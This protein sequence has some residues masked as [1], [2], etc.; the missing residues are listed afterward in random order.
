MS[1][2]YHGRSIGYWVQRYVEADQVSVE[3]ATEILMEIGWRARA[4]AVPVALEMLYDADRH[5]EYRFEAATL[6][7]IVGAVGELADALR[8]DDP[9]VREAALT[10][11]P[12][13]CIA[14]ARETA[15]VLGDKLREGTLDL[16]RREETLRGILH[17]TRQTREHAT[18]ALTDVLNDPEAD[19]TDVACVLGRMATVQRNAVYRLVDALNGDDDSLRDQAGLALASILQET[20]PVLKALQNLDDDPGNSDLE[21]AKGVLRECQEVLGIGRSASTPCEEPER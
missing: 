6:L 11:L 14:N 21:R 3:R 12:W 20:M 16:E 9:I 19:K 8:A 2:T 5:D 10:S 7:A 15:R 13:A 17:L 1:E 18:Q 4:E